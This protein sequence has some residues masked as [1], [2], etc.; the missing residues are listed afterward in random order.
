MTVAHCL[1]FIWAY[2]PRIGVLRLRLTIFDIPDHAQYP[3]RHQNSVKLSKS[4]IVSKPGW[5]SSISPSM[6]I[7]YVDHTYQWKACLHS[8]YSWTIIKQT[9]CRL[10]KPPTH[11][12]DNHS[13]HTP[14]LQRHPK[15]ISLQNLHILQTLPFQLP[16]HALMR[17]HGHNIKPFLPLREQLREFARSG[18]QVEYPRAVAPGYA[19]M[20]QNLRDGFG[21]VRGAVKVVG[22]C[23]GEAA[24]CHI[25]ERGQ[26]YV[27]FFPLVSSTFL[28]ILFSFWVPDEDENEYSEDLLVDK[29]R[30]AY[31][32]GNRQTTCL[33]NEIIIDWTR[34]LKHPENFS[35]VFAFDLP[36]RWTEIGTWGHKSVKQAL[37][38]ME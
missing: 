4:L 37:L 30:D 10:K 8:H 13:I 21:R 34:Q 14:L 17:L 33:T 20:G 36:D 31:R 6:S 7:R 11:L 38:S 1:S 22:W 15:C 5:I 26:H 12:S 18:G 19:Q 35:E 9:R 28:I 2:L 32:I 24:D 23:G 3:T 27:L 29:L 25:C 16:P